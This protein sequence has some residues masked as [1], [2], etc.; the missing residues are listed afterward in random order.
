MEVTYE[1]VEE[2]TIPLR[3]GSVVVEHN[4]ES[5]HVINFYNYPTPEEYPDLPKVDMHFFLVGIKPIPI[6]VK[7]ALVAD[8]ATIPNIAAGLSYIHLGAEL[9]SQEMALRLMALG[10][11]IGLWDI[12]DPTTIGLTGDIANKLIGKGFVYAVPNRESPLLEKSRR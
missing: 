9:G 12:M 5:I 7:L 2:Y 11:H 8:I 1:I 10:K 4:L 6:E 3:K